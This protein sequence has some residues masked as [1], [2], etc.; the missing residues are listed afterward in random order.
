MSTVGYCEFCK[1]EFLG[2]AGNCPICHRP[3]K[4]RIF[5]SEQKKSAKSSRNSRIRTGSGRSYG[6]GGAACQ[7]CP[8]CY[9]TADWCPFMD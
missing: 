8:V 1:K 4:S 9:G 7:Y 3:M 2:S 6:A 5:Q